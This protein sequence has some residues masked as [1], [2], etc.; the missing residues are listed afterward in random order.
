MTPTSM[1]LIAPPARLFF[2]AMALIL[3]FSAGITAQAAPHPW[4]NLARGNVTP[5]YVTLDGNAIRDP[6]SDPAY[7][8]RLVESGVQNVDGH[9]VVNRPAGVPSHPFRYF[10]ASFNFLMF[11]GTGADGFSFNYGPD[12]NNYFE[13]QEEIGTSAGLAVAFRINR[14]SGASDRVQVYYDDPRVSTLNV[15]IWDSTFS[16]QHGTAE[17]S[18]GPTG[19]TVIVRIRQWFYGPVLQT[20]TVAQDLVIPGW[21]PLASWKFFMGARNGANTSR[22]A[23]TDLNI[24]TDSEPPSITG[25]PLSRITPEDTAFFFDFTVTDREDP[26]G[27]VVSASVLGGGPVA[28]SGLTISNLGGNQRRLTVTPTLNA[29]GTALVTISATQDGDTTSLPLSVVVTPVNDPPVVVALPQIITEDGTL[30]MSFTVLDVDT[31][32]TS[33]TTTVSSSNPALL[34]ASAIQITGTSSARNLTA[35]PNAHQHGNTTITI[36]ANDGAGGASSSPFVLIVNPVNDAPVAGSSYALQLDG[37]NDY[38]EAPATGLSNGNQS[39]SIEAWVN[40]DSVTNRAWLLHLGGIGNGH[41]WLL[42]NATATEATMLFGGW[43]IPTLQIVTLKLPLGRWAHLA[44]TYDATTKLYILYLDGTEVGRTTGNAASAFNLQAGLSIGRAL[45]GGGD[46]HLDGS[47]DDVRVWNRVLTPQEIQRNLVRP[48]TGRESGLVQYLRFDEG[49]NVIAFNT[50]RNPGGTAATLVNGASWRVRH[51]DFGI[52]LDGINDFVVVPHDAQLNGYPLTVSAWFRTTHSASSN[53]AIVNKYQDASGNG[54]SVHVQNGELHAWFFRT[55]GSVFPDSNGL[56][57]GFVSD[58]QWHHV[59]FVVDASG[60]RLFLDGILKQSASWSGSP[61]A[62]TATTPLRFGQYPSTFPTSGHFKGTIADVSLWNRSFTNPEATDLYRRRPVPAEPNLIAFWPLDDVSGTTAFDRTATPLNGTLSNG[63]A[64]T[65]ANLALAFGQQNVPEDTVWPIFL[66]SLD[67]EYERAEVA[68]FTFTILTPP[69]HG[70]LNLSSGNLVSAAQNPVQ[71][72]PNADYNGPDSFRYRVTDQAGVTAEGTVLLE[73]S[74]DNDLPVISG[75]VNLVVEEDTSSGAIPFTVLDADHP[76]DQIN[77]IVT[78]DSPNLIPNDSQH[79]VLGGSGSGRTIEIIP[80]LNEIG[81]AQISI[82]ASDPLFGQDQVTFKVRVDPKP[83]YALFDLGTLSDPRNRSFGAALNDQGWVVGWAQTLDSP[84]DDGLTGRKS[85]AHAFLRRG[86][87]SQSI[88]DLGTL[89]TDTASRSRAFAINNNNLISG[90]ANS[91]GAGARE[92]FRWLGSTMT[93]VSAQISGGNDSIGFAINESGDLAGSFQLTGLGRRAFRLTANNTFLNLGV[94]AGGTASEAF[95]IDSAGVVVGYSGIAGTADR[96]FRYAGTLGDLGVLP[97]HHSSR[98]YGINDDGLVV[99]WS[100]TN[101][102]PGS[103]RLA[104]LYNGATTPSMRSLGLLPNGNFSEAYA[105]NA[106]GQVVGDADRRL[107]NGTTES[108]AFLHTA[109]QMRDISDLIHDSRNFVFSQSTWKLSSARAINRGGAIVGTGLKDSLPRAYLAVPAWA[110]GRQIARPENAVPRRPE[111]EIISGSPGDTRENAFHWS[112]FEKRLYPIRPVTATIRWFTSQTDVS[113]EGTNIVVNSDRITVEGLCVWPKQPLVHVAT[114]PVQVEPQGVPFDFGFQSVIHETTGGSARY[115]AT[116]KTFNSSAA[117]Y[118]VLYYLKTDGAAPNP[119]IQR[120]RF[121]VAR[122]YRWDLAPTLVE[123]APAFVGSKLVDPTHQEYLSRSGHVLFPN[124]FY[125]GHGPDRAH[126]RP[127]RRGPIIPVNREPAGDTSVENDLVVVWYRFSPIG[128]AWASVPTRYSVSWPPDG[129]VDKIIIASGEGSGPLPNSLFPNKRVYNQPDPSL[130]GYNPNEEHALLSDNALYALRDDLNAVIS[131]ERSRPYALLKYKDPAT[132]DWSI[133]PYKVVAEEAPF[134][135]TYNKVAG[136]EIAPPAPLFTLPLCPETHG[137]SGPWWEDF[138][139]KLYARAA[140]ANGA[141][142]DVVLR[143]FYPLQPDFYYDLNSDGAAD[144]PV[145]TSLA[146]LDRRTQSALAS[147]NA[148]AGVTGQPLDITYRVTWPR[149]GTLQIGQTLLNPRSSASGPL[150]GVKN[151]AKLQFVYDDLTPNWNP[152][153]SPTPPILTL[154]RLYD[155]LSTRTYRLAVGESIPAVVQRSNR[156]GKEYFNDL[157]PTLIERLTFDPINKWLQFSGTLDEI[158]Y[159]GEPLLLPNVLSSRERDDIRGLVPVGH[160]ARD[161]WIAIVDNLYDATRNPNGVDLLPLD[162]QADSASDTDT[163]APPQILPQAGLRIGLLSEFVATNGTNPVIT[164]TDRSLLPGDYTVIRTNVLPEPLGALPKALTTALGGVPPATF[165]PVN[166]LALAGTT[167]DFVTLPQVSFGAGDAMTVELWLNPDSLNGP[168]NSLVRQ[169]NATPDWALEFRGGG[170]EIAFVLNAGGTEST[171]MLP[172]VPGDFIGTW[173]HLAATFD[174]EFMRLFVDG[175]LQAELPKTGLVQSTGTAAHL[176]IMVTSPTTRENPFDGTFDEVRL[177]SAALPAFV[178]KRDGEKRLFGDEDF[179]VR[180]HRF[181]ETGGTQAD[182][183]A[184]GA[185]NGALSGNV[186]FIESDAPTGARPRYL[187]LVENNDPALG[188]LPIQL[189]IIRV[190]DGPYIGDMKALYPGNVFD[191]RLT[192]RHS[193]EF[194]GD[195]DPVQFEWYYKPDAA[196]F[197]PTEMPA[198]GV[199]GDITD[200]RGW[201][202]YTSGNR[203]L[204]D[205]APPALLDARQGVNDITLGEGGESSLLALGDTWFICRYRGFNVRGQTTWSE[206]IGDPSGGGTP[207]AM[208]AEGWIKRV[209]RGLNPFDA[210]VKDFHSNP[211]ATYASLILQAGGRYEG[212]IAFSPSADNLNSIGL[213]EAYTTVLNRG[214]KLSIDQGQNF[215][216]ANNA[217]LLATSRISDLYMLLGNEAFADAADPTIGFTTSDGSYSAQATSIFAFQNQL[218]SLIEEELALL[219]GRDDTLAGVAA[220]P[221]YNRV[222]WNFTLGEGEIAYQR[223]YNISDQTADGFID[224][225][226]ARKLYPQGHGDAWG[227]YLTS[228]KTYY[229]LLQHTNFTWVPRSESVLVAGQPVS[230]DFFDERKFAQAAA[231]RAK[232]GREIVDLTYRANY[233]EDPAGQ[234]QGYKDTRSDRSW[235]VDEWSRRAGQGAY[236]DWVTANAI[237]PATDPNPSHVGIQKIDRTTV[238]DL[239]EIRSQFQDIQSVMDAADGGLNPVGLAKGAIVFDIDP[240]FLAVGSTAAIGRQA[241][242]GLAHFEQLNERAIKMLKNAVRVWD[243]ANKA[244]ESLRQTQDSVDEFTTNVLDEERD[245]KN[246]LIEIYGYPHAGNIGPGKTYPSGYDGP[247]LYF[248]N[249]LPVTEVT[250]TTAPPSADFITA[251]FKPMDDSGEFRYTFTT[252]LPPGDPSVLESEI[253]PVLYPIST[254]SSDWIFDAPQSWGQ[255]RA[256]GE[257]Q[258]ALS[259]FLQANTRLKLAL[260]NYDGLILDIKDQLAQLQAQRNL[261]AEILGIR[262][263]Q[264]AAFTAMNISL[265]IMNGVEVNLRRTAGLARDVN[266]ALKEGLPK[267][268]GLASDVTFLPRAIIGGATA[269]SVFAME[270]VADNLGVAQNAVDLAKEVA[271]LGFDLGVEGATLEFEI[272]QRAKELEKTVRNEYNVRLEAFNEAEVVRQSFG[273]YLAKLAEGERFIQQRLVFR[274]RTAAA[275]TELR[276]T[277]AAFRIFR[278]EAV[279]KYRATFDMAARY[280]YLSATAYDYESNFLGTDQRAGRHF[281]TQIIRQRN[282]GVLVDGEPI[283]G[284]A[285][286][287]DIQGRMLQNWEVLEPQFGLNNPQLETANL[288]VRNEFFRMRDQDPDASDDPTDLRWRAALNDPSVRVKDLWQVPEFR[289]F[290]RPFAAERLG[291]QPALVLRMPTTVTFGLNFFGWPL[292]G[293]DTAFDP[294]HYSTKINYAGITFRGYNEAQLS[295]APRVYLFPTG[296]DTLRSPT[297]DDLATR[298]WRVLDQAL[299]QPFAIGANDLGNPAWIPQNNLFGEPFTQLRRFASLRAYPANDDFDEASAITSSRLVGRSVWNTQWVLIIPGGTLLDDPEAGINRF[300]NSVTDIRIGLAV[301]SFPGN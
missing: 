239:D 64:Y 179:L 87:A 62:P 267:V 92:A 202:A 122:T 151:M 31:P 232:T 63:A 97:N 252:D 184:G 45:Q 25:V 192:L 237:L 209:I 40:V 119:L 8:V 197:I 88:E 28:T 212:D 24:S 271:G 296:M 18:Y 152:Q 261:K 289:R 231:A 257:I 125:D 259:D 127:S 285:G 13:G 131:P 70:T 217:L 71:Y 178:L 134:F 162:G 198:T 247:D 12:S 191:Q 210:R 175:R 108:R 109:G 229:T 149:V 234:W 161:G 93:G 262:G 94:L 91:S 298:E 37:S 75:L 176:G 286:L 170:T 181:D 52:L 59:A 84:N 50:S 140:G 228:I 156:N 33:V 57:G 73:V 138:Q 111:I 255:R 19:L 226:D 287:A 47:V 110:I 225:K 32:I 10:N 242:Q 132:G 169:G 81:T 241:V 167:N 79:I 56:D 279:Q 213:I 258:E 283:P 282:L 16:S 65:P 21:N 218:D 17:I 141:S 249:Y 292:S 199:N 284:Q 36:A 260:Q 61:G 76:S 102:Q 99:G 200:A 164:L 135:F 196:G 158:S 126:D 48:L 254:S 273:K 114:A 182:D 245:F 150:P 15:D 139:G 85:Q 106:F 145:G 276:Y 9:L 147:P 118:S 5:S 89:G 299:P 236:F 105:I 230:V 136:V 130:P 297:G 3:A 78:S 51:D 177:W 68:T 251:V 69:T 165:H 143:W 54:Y 281:L 83:A 148:A 142:T 208:L 41:H 66:P 146:W 274:R 270:T 173:R 268:I 238:L 144:A 7:A 137:V 27:I 58:G 189:H 29:H 256:P 183:A 186:S 157:P 74:G 128:V 112:D 291:P 159:V 42:Q 193:S 171:L 129:S 166:A 253:L 224:E 295:S 11:G 250:G 117:G 90:F 153:V 26:S 203:N 44:T 190:D 20:Y 185:Q 246:R 30:N 38:A 82:T 235:G 243:E 124:T 294:S 6:A 4:L 113:G 172:V 290:C 35:S 222:L 205:P 103:P 269:G 216:P 272:L 120:P 101:A 278:N 55:G 67:V 100:R 174:G 214:R 220:Q 107:D 227:H 233:V 223:V 86:L 265:A 163:N 300:I 201:I 72:T 215:D 123:N 133:K 115:D 194:G 244:T 277:D 2:L 104:F 154:A 301:Y 49:Q 168:A 188:A 77:L 96:A 204:S 23:V 211:S 195:P 80:A 116:S 98:A 240:T 1:P 43:N 60:G 266:D 22:V 46:T 293:G 275:A 206:W 155:P 219:R 221:V 53:G 288:S 207:R 95:A 248:Y 180:Y 187:T 264:I 121:E 160:A 263:G 39:H 34:P 280:V 14:P